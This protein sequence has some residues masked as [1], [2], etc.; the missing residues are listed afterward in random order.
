MTYYGKRYS[1]VFGLRGQ[2]ET[3]E[4]AAFAARRRVL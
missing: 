1:L 2:Q 4:I 3:A